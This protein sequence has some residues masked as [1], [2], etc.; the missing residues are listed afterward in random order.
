MSAT[1]A[2][3]VPHAHPSHAPRVPTAADIMRRT[4]VTLTPEMPIFDAV[5]T[6]LKHEISGAPV[7]DAD[8][9]IV[10][11]CSELDC[12]RILASGE[13]YADDH[14]E[15]G[16]VF[17]LGV[18]VGARAHLDGGQP[19]GDGVDQR[20]GHL[21]HGQHH[22]D[23]HAALTGRAVGGGHGGVGGHVHVGVG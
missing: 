2:T 11:I 15:E 13:F 14:R 5:R 9:R 16:V 8:G 6:L 18:G 1:H 4:L 7:V 22:R 20:V 19:G 12:L 17:H 21:A 23:G 3:H 10:G